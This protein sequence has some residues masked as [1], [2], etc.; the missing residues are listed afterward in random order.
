MR[1]IGSRGLQECVHES[2]MSVHEYFTLVIGLCS[3]V[4]HD[5]YKSVS[6]EIFLTHYSKF[7][8]SSCSF[9]LIVITVFH[10]T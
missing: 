3:R 1:V 4:F 7:Y 5:G 8:L 2:Y 9:E 6:P 10:S